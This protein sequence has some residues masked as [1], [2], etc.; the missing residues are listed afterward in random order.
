MGHDSGVEQAIAALAADREHGATDLAR[1]ALDILESA[2]AAFPEEGLGANLDGVGVLIV[3]SRPG[4]ASVRSAVSRALADGPLVHPGQAK[5]AFARA[6]AWLD[7]AAKA[8]IEETASMIPDGATIV[9]CSYSGT[10]LEACVSASNSGKQIKVIVL[11][12]KVGDIAYGERM[13][14][15]LLA[16]GVD[17]EVYP[18]GVSMAGLGDLTMALI[19]ADRVSPDGSLV[20]G[21]PSLLLAEH[22]RGVAPFYVAAETFKLDDTEHVEEGLEPVPPGLIT[23][24]VTDRGVVQPDQVWK[25]R[26][27]T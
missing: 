10:V 1:E 23:G 24:Y 14:E 12:S 6:R 11:T 26:G 3:L 16:R 22:V 2:A 15:A 17:A 5:R 27:T 13:A 7:Y 4:M 8:T 21:I 18:D 19:G 9:T 25:L 20:N